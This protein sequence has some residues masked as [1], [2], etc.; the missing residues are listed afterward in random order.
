MNGM[1]CLSFSW[2]LA[3]I[4]C[5]YHYCLLY[6]SSDKKVVKIGIKN[7]WGSVSKLLAY[8]VYLIV[9]LS[10]HSGKLE[11]KMS[12][13]HIEY[14]LL[15]LKLQLQ[16]NYTVEQEPLTYLFIILNLWKSKSQ[17]YFTFLLCYPRY[18][19]GCF[20]S[21]FEKLSTVH[22]NDVQPPRLLWCV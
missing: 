19:C 7:A 11:R 9:K 5:S 4:S 13:F 12:C 20:F 22:A 17:Q 10:F 3:I 8:T 15:R 21:F 14:E 16:E 1:P 18:L 6:Q 2:L